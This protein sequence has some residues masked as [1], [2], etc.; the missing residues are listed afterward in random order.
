[1]ENEVILLDI[2][3]VINEP[4]QRIT[5]CMQQKLHHLARHRE[6]YFLTGNT[7]TKS[8]DILDG[9]ISMYSGIF[10]LNA[11]ELR[12]MRGK[13]VWQDEETPSLP[14]KIED[15]LRCLLSVKDNVHSG[16]RIEWRNPRMLNFSHIGRFASQDM[17]RAHDASW[18]EETI[19][20]L[21]IGYPMVE[22]VA[23][24]SISIDIYSR[25]ADKARACKYINAKGKNFI[26]IGDKTE[27]GG[28][29]YPVKTYCE[30]NN[31][32]ICLQSLGPNHTM[33]MID[34]VLGRV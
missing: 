34:V 28:N 19:E 12:T 32:N 30:S 13:L 16:N 9:P 25:G 3:G 27:P 8:I 15:S 11:D 2:D 31:K 1:M 33:E 23:G 4:Q 24:G 29:D 7:Y 22:A 17:R 21:K 5:S 18:R 10:C 20:F 26:F 6:V 14:V